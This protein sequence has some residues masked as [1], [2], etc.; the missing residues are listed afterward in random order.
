MSDTDEKKEGQETKNG[1]EVLDATCQ[2]ADNGSSQPVAS[3]SGQ[4]G[5]RERIPK[6]DRQVIRI[7]NMEGDFTPKEIRQLK[8]YISNGM[9]GLHAMTEQKQARAFQL[10]NAGRGYDEIAN[11]ICVRK[12]AILYI[13]DRERWYD[14]KM[15]KYEN[16]VNALRPRLTVIQV[17]SKH[18][19]MDLVQ[20]THTYYRDRMDEYLRSKDPKVLDSINH[21][22]L[23]KYL[24]ALE[25]LYKLDNKDN[26]A[27]A[28]TVNLAIPEGSE[29]KRVDQNTVQVTPTQN[30][31]EDLA[32]ILEALAELNRA[33]DER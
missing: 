8:A 5:K 32:A 9:P 28:P 11:M 26:P 24:K 16:M 13:A 25:L 31:K 4:S 19:L 21:K 33:R 6:P 3:G 14:Q 23:D 2:P 22:W 29:I 30:S 15:E 7:N 27:N 12:E 1:T 10:Y 18:F 20:A 17:E